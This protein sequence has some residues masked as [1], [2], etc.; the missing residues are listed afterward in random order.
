MAAMRLHRPS[1]KSKIASE[2]SRSADF[3]QGRPKQSEFAIEA[4]V[5]A[6]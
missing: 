3:T 6:L 2:A 1:M 4:V 5:E